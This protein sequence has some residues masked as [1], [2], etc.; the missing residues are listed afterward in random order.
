MYPRSY[1][2]SIF[3]DQSILIWPRL[4]AILTNYNDTIYSIMVNQIKNRLPKSIYRNILTFFIPIF[5]LVFILFFI[6][7][8]NLKLEGSQQFSLLAKAFLHGH[9]NFLTSIG[10]KGQD[11]I[12]YHGKIYWGEGP[13]P[14]IL[15]MPFVGV[16]NLLHLFFYQGYLDILLILG[17]LC[18]VYRFARHLVFSKK[19]SLILMFGFALGSVFIG[20]AEASSGWLFAQI[21]TTFLIFWGLH[22]FYVRKHQ[23]W[24][25]IGIICALVLMTRA[26][27]S[28]LIIFFCLEFWRPKTIIP[29]KFK[30]FVQLCLPFAIAIILLGTYNYLRF[31][32]PFNGGFAYQLISPPSV[33]ARSLGIFSLIHIPTNLYS[34]LLRGPVPVLRSS[35][36]WTLNFPY[37]ENN[38]YGMSI[39]ITSPYLLYLFTRKWQSYDSR[40][41]HLMVAILASSLLVF[42]YYGLG[43][44]QFGY[45]YTLDFL[46]ELFILFMISYRSKNERLSRGM[47]TLLIGSGFLNFYLLLPYLFG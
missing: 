19:D 6:L 23:R 9:L 43:M 12:L 29:K 25:L 28:P 45:R 46:P 21:I 41:R 13:F 14:A 34:A 18:F 27:A 33:K 47:K 2:Q 36:S 35:T 39:F 17:I 4:E 37:I 11:P 44:L 30:K 8:L 16:F 40:S 7:V 20:V 31:H 1:R 42:S 32:S 38:I 15:L 26:T 22:E 3:G 10:G 5:I 24:W